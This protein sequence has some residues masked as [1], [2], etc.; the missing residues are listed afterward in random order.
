MTQFTMENFRF[1]VTKISPP[2][3]L[4]TCD[5]SQHVSSCP[6]GHTSSV[7]HW[8]AVS[9]RVLEGGRGRDGKDGGKAGVK[10]K[11]EEGSGG[12]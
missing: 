7:C 8:I 5:C 1:Y 10:G 3:Y 2:N 4:Y 11:E 12:G 9:E 6:C